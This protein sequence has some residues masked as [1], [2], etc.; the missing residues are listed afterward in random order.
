[1][2]L[3][4]LYSAEKAHRA[5]EESYSACLGGIGAKPDGNV[6][7]YTVGFDAT[8]A[9]GS[10]TAGAGCGRT[11]DGACSNYSWELSGLPKAGK[12]CTAGAADEKATPPV[13][14]S[15]YT[16]T[17]AVGASQA[18]AL[19]ASS[20]AIKYNSFKA[21]AAGCI[22]SSTQLDTWTVDESK[23]I[24]NDPVGIE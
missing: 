16:A 19:A 12:S 5:V 8:A 10:T 11:T 23:K 17:A 2:F 18:G 1:V 21:M 3:A 14:G 20:T 7:Y 13:D 6:R 9:K 22:G 4:V 24:V 15:F